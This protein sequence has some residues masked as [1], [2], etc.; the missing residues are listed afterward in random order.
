MVAKD[1]LP[2]YGGFWSEKRSYNFAVQHGDTVFRAGGGSDSVKE[3]AE[4]R[5]LYLSHLLVE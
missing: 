3:V 5:V 2:D 4:I 1:V